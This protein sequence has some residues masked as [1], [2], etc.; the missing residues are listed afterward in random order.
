M[1]PWVGPWIM[2]MGVGVGAC[3]DGW[4]GWMDG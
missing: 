2:A 3:M 4:N 1:V